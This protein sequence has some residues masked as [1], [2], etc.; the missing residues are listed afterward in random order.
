MRLAN[1]VVA[2][3]LASRF[4]GVASRTTDVIRY[5]GR[6]SGRTFTTPT[7]YVDWEDGIV[8]FVG[9][10]GRK[11]WWRNFRTERDLDVLLRGEWVPMVGRAVVGA[12][13]AT[14]VAPLLAAYLA[15]FPKVARHLPGGAAA[16]YGAVLV[17]CRPRPG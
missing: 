2:A 17:Q 14:A 4:H 8:I 13:D 9:R 3:V 16:T 1:R 12:D 10:S 11:E 5:T 15:K 7:Q 6:R